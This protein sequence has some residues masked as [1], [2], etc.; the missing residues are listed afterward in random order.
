VTTLLGGWVSVLRAGSDPLP[1]VDVVDVPMTLAGL[2]RVN[3]ENAAVA[4][5]TLALRFSVEQVADG[6]RSFDPSQDNPGRM[7]ISTLSVPSGV[8][9][10]VIDLA[11]NEAGLE[12]L[13]EIMNGLRPRHGR[14]LFGVGT[15]GDR[16]DDVSSG[17]EGS[18]A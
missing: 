8:I 13:L 15:A 3:V 2:S 10:V 1:V 6:L 4:L 17:S 16:S 11:H 18:P 12:A 7:N 5:A 14:L 9:S